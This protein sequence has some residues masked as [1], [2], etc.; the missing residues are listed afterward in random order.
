MI[1]HNIIIITVIF[2]QH[3]TSV[4]L[5]SNC[6]RSETFCISYMYESLYHAIEN[7]ANQNAGKSLYIRQYFTKISDQLVH[8][9]QPFHHWDSHPFLSTI[10]WLLIMYLAFYATVH[11]MAWCKIVLLYNPFSWY[12]IP[13]NIP[14]IIFICIFLIYILT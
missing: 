12:C 4:K 3:V 11:S 9:T 6:W 10:V 13:W 5:Q 8:H 14:L 2:S 1:Q 7:T